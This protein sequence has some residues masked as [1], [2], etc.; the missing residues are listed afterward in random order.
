MRLKTVMA[1]GVVTLAVASG[2]G[3]TTGSLLSEEYQTIYVAPFQNV[4]REYDL[5]A[6]LT[7]A[8][9]R[10]FTTD[11]RLRVVSRDEADLLLEGVITGYNLRGLTYDEDDN[12][13][14]FLMAITAAAPFASL[15]PHTLS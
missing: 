4:S 12:I 14:Q 15:L 5:Q 9:S 3:Y 8:T 13:T 6:P 2:C 10:K 7:T 1:A 11:T